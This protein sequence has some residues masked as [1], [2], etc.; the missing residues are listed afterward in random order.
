MYDPI[1]AVI[2]PGCSVVSV[3]IPYRGFTISI[4]IDDGTLT[5]Q[6]VLKRGDL[7]VFKGDDDVT[8]SFFDDFSD[9]YK[10]TLWML[11][12]LKVKIDAF[13]D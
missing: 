5:D 7:L 2:T 6:Q 9:A 11:S 12:D 1:Y 3:K 4:G 10:P 8:L 13:L